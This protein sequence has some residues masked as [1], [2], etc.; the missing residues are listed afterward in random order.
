MMENVVNLGPS[1]EL[2]Q[3]LFAKLQSHT[4]Q[5][6]CHAFTNGTTLEGMA[7]TLQDVTLKL[8]DE[9]LLNILTMQVTSCSISRECVSDTAAFGNKTEVTQVD[10]CGWSS[11]VALVVTKGQR[12]EAQDAKMANACTMNMDTN[13]TMHLCCSTTLLSEVSIKVLP[14]QCAPVRCYQATRLVSTP[15]NVFTMQVCTT[16]CLAS[17]KRHNASTHWS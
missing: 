1:P 9:P 3:W 10:C 6:C 5:S 8:G 11:L 13:Q 14:G 7:K 15:K 2:E 17:K 16:K 12:C 4:L